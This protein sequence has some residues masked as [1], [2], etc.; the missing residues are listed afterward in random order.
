[1]GR[2]IQGQEGRRGAARAAAAP[3]GDARATIGAAWAGLDARAISEAS[4]D[5]VKALAD[6]MGLRIDM[7]PVVGHRPGPEAEAHSEMHVRRKERVNRLY[8]VLREEEARN[9]ES[10]RAAEL[11]AEIGRGER[12]RSLERRAIAEKIVLAGRDASRRGEL[13][14][15][16]R[17]M[18]RKAMWPHCSEAERVV[19]M[20]TVLLDAGRSMAASELSERVH[21]RWGEWSTEG[22]MYAARYAGVV[23]HDSY[24]VITLARPVDPG[25][26]EGW[27]WM[28]EAMERAVGCGAARYTGAGIEMSGAGNLT[29]REL[30]GATAVAAG[31]NACGEPPGLGQWLRENARGGRA[32]TW[33]EA[34]VN[35][36]GA[37]AEVG[38]AYARL[39]A[40]GRAPPADPREAEP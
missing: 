16:I 19:R 13:F 27:D 24:G 35:A 32:L 36:R 37:N 34:T 20:A 9:G 1:M 8:K 26:P 29:P 3:P 21:D 10:R 17:G 23:D 11:R 22:S 15:A 31:V 30:A 25:A 14:A 39:V 28:Y 7:W 40:Q 5:T 18:L 2:G 6:R 12:A 33:E 38:E 4:A